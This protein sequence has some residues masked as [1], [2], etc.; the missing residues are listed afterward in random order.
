MPLRRVVGD[1][2]C[3]VPLWP[4]AIE[5]PSC[6]QQ[7][8]DGF[9]LC[10]MCGAALAG[11]PATVREERKVV[12]VLFC[13]LVGSTARAEGLDPED[14]R[15]LLSRFHAQVR[16][17]LER[18]GGTVEKFVGDAVM[19]LFGAPISHE[20][21][22]ERAVRAALAIRDFATAEGTELRIGVTTGE[23]LVA[24]G[25]RP[26]EG[27]GMASGDVVN[28]AARLQTAAPVN[29]IL[30]DAS[31][32]R[33]TR[34]I[35]TY[36]DA[37]GVTAKG[38]AQPIPAW[39][40]LEARSRFG[41]DV[42]HHARVPL[43]GREQEL[44][45]LRT[46]LNRA[47]GE[48]VPQLVTLVAVPGMGK[49]R[50]IY[51]LSRIADDEKE[52]ITWRQGRCLAYGDGVTYWALGE[53]VKAQA[54]IVEQDTT[55]TATEKLSASAA[56]ILEEDRERA[57]VE[58]HLRPLVGVETAT[59]LGG[60]RRGEA[61]AAWRRY[62][63][64]LA[65]RRPLVLVLEDLHWA[66]DGLLDFIDELI[67][68]LTDVPLLVV[69]SARPELLQRRPGWGGG[70]LNASTLALAA[71]SADQ[72]ATLL[73]AVLGRPSLAPEVARTLLERV[74]GNP[75]Y[76][77]QFAELVLERGAGDKLALP[78][79]LQGIV[80]ARLDGL[81]ADEKAVLQEAAV[82][83]K[84]FWAGS[85]SATVAA[86]GLGGTD[87]VLQVLAR[88]GFLTRQRRSS[89]EQ[90]SEWSFAHMLLR[91]VA[92][93]QIPR[94]ERSAKHR[95]AAEWI[96]SLGRPDDHAELLAHHWK[97]ALELAAAAGIETTD[98]VDPARLALR[99][100]GDRSYAV[101]AYPAAARFYGDALAL[102]PVDDPERS[103]LLYRRADALYL[104]DDQDAEQ[105]LIVGRDALLGSG[106]R[107]TAAQAELA[108]SRIWWHRGLSEKSREHQRRALELAGAGSSLTTAWVRAM[109]ARTDA[110]GGNPAVG[111]RL[112]SEAFAVAE[113][114][115]ADE[116]RAHAL[117]TIGLSKRYLGDATG[118]EDEQRALELAIEIHSPI[119]GS[120]ANNVAVGAFFDFD[121]VHAGVLFEEGLPI[122][123]RFGD[124]AGAKWLRAQVANAAYIFGRWDDALPVA[125]AFIAASEAGALTYQDPAMR[126]IRAGIRQA[127]G[128]LVGSL[129]DWRAA[130][131]RGRD[132]G[133]PQEL[134]VAVGGLSASLALQGFI[135]E[136]RAAGAETVALTARAPQEAAWAL[137]FDFI[138]SPV[139]LEFAEEL[140]AMVRD[141]PYEKWK[142]L[143]L[144][145]LDRNFARAAEMWAD[146]GSPVWEARL[147]MRAA[148]DLIE[149]G[150]R[151]EA[152]EQI[153][154]A[155]AFY[156]TVGG[157]FW[158]DRGEALLR[159]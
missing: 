131:A 60:D 95:R 23:A 102:W 153:A 97:T 83:G 158:M 85:L 28:T 146:A 122:A 45:A 113:E 43:V 143:C 18:H 98:L 46:A 125:E 26:R 144:A 94:A 159:A 92:Y 81:A 16:M 40:A 115:G 147:R 25:A 118:R 12:T 132:I 39:E 100:A 36:R 136:A 151:E 82:M 133:D 148:E 110:I 6:G 142:E 15:A 130:A 29:G 30:V 99:A 137:A 14:V 91:D 44:D 149:R 96:A 76:A 56:E 152:A 54:G 117:A 24:L 72:T 13:D 68:W 129:T 47:I 101:N 93:A 32:H 3:R 140:R 89:V 58:R 4:M 141:S 106:D 50:L 42:T 37:A 105:A 84:V 5:C 150:R 65:D 70:K 127:R 9:R 21:D 10:G 2:G 63:E 134:L 80:A 66:D 19:A 35:I 145:C 41:V 59:G 74:D 22:P 53:V 61:F 64:A 88:K 17:E 119:A 67:D 107:E 108:L 79:S 103:M 123:E 1:G 49:S 111:L 20:D 114:L 112:A 86:K 128:D 135:D 38:K 7:N 77:E 116:L 109:I 121:L 78:E 34:N 31:T 155:R 138:F 57:W 52:L 51:E 104:A 156:E 124:A 55:A 71:L 90:E 75:L 87:G 154:L 139:A 62:L 11:P 73:S 126:E 33:A 27:E 120:I 8:P 48:R 157:T 69:C